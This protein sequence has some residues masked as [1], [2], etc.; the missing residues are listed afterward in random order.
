HLYT[1]ETRLLENFWGIREPPI[2]EAID[3]SEIDLVI[4]P[5]LCFDER[6][7]RVGH[8]KGFYDKF[9]AGCRADCLKVGFTFFPPTDPIDD[10][11]EYDVPLDQCVTP[12]RVYVFVKK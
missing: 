8:G 2:D 1:P 12:E 11:D 5:L 3:P 6:G 10:I 9:L 7:F 4:V